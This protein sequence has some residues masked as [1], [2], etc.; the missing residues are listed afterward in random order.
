M[1]ELINLWSNQCR[2]TQDCAF[3]QLFMLQ[4]RIQDFYGVG[5]Q[6]TMCAYVHHVR[7][8]R[9]TLLSGWRVQGPLKV[10]G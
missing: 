10:I 4:G 6:K 5:V 2:P 8:A 3:H 1:H 7:E 9:S